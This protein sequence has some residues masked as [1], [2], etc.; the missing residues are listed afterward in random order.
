MPE[1]QKPENKK[2][3]VNKGGIKTLLVGGVLLLCVLIWIQ[4]GSGQNNAAHSGG[5]KGNPSSQG[6]TGSQSGKDNASRERPASRPT[7]SAELI[8]PVS[9]SSSGVVLMAPWG[10]SSPNQ[11]G[12]DRPMEGNP[13]GPMS[14]V[15]G[16]KGELFVLDQVNK[17]IVRVGE[18]GKP[19]PPL[20]L[21][22]DGVQDM[23]LAADGNL[24]LLD[25]LVNKS[26][27]VMGPDG[28]TIAKYPLEEETVGET[29]M[30]TGVF[31]D[32]TDIYVEKEHGTLVSIGSTKGGKT[33]KKELLGRPS[34]DGKLLLSAGI[35]DGSAGRIYCSAINR[36]TNDHEFTREYRMTGMVS[37]LL[38][39][40]SDKG[41][42]I[43]LASELL[44]GEQGAVVVLMCL[45][46]QKGS[47]IG[48]VELPANII[49]EESMR[50][51]SVLDSGGVVYARRT[52]NG[53]SYE[54]YDCNK[55]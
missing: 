33:T 42:T 13:E 9:V 26:V 32:G 22:M 45:E 46:P 8:E 25:R 38:L 15:T 48:V 4:W 37:T 3:N 12:R 47:P 55:K 14:L 39:L 41:G 30:L 2:E 54:K 34:R 27:V 36:S 11:V 51:F 17:R 35:T 44:A 18:D 16:P 40:D 7:V 23:T 5:K 24:V 53:V 29:G 10:G 31:T 50:D 28:Q 19:L 52:D 1:A 20:A 21:P 6:K 49:P 43:Y